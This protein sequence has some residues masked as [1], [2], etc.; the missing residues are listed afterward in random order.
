MII[1]ILMLLTGIIISFLFLSWAWVSQIRKKG[2]KT[3]DEVPSKY[4]LPDDVVDSNIVHEIV[5]LHDHMESIQREYGYV[6]SGCIAKIQ[7]S[8]GT[9][10][11]FDLVKLANLCLDDKNIDK[12]QSLIISV[13][14]EIMKRKCK[15]K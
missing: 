15:K 5:L 8:D 10:Q 2:Y 14:N 9:K 11:S 4:I 7:F 6:A 12:T 3:L 1:N 13:Y